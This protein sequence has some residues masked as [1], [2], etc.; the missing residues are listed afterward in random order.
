VTFLT[1]VIICTQN[2]LKKKFYYDDDDDNENNDDDDDDDDDDENDDDDDD[3][4]DD[5]ND[6]MKLQLPLFVRTCFRSIGWFF[7][8][9]IMP[10]VPTQSTL[11][12]DS[13]Q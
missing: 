12:A 8:E 10:Q 2:S 5:G 6:A 13:V 9:I 11:P 3:D 1:L 4:D 7:T